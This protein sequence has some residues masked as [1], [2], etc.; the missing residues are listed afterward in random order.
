MDNFTFT[1]CTFENL[2]AANRGKIKDMSKNR[3]QHA[4]QGR[5]ISKANKSFENV[6]KLKSLG[7]QS[8]AHEENKSILNAGNDSE[9]FVFS[10]AV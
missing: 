4:R 5:A 9:T 6:A 8:L 1:T 2:P 3:H 10:S 7:D